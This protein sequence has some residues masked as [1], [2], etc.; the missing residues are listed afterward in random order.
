MGDGHGTRRK[1][2]R[3]YNVVKILAARSRGKIWFGVP[4][5]TDDAGVKVPWGVDRDDPS[6][7]QGELVPVREV[8]AERSGERI[9]EST[10]RN[11]IEGTAEQ[12]ERANDREALT[13][14][15]SGGVYP[16]IVWRRPSVL[17]GEISPHA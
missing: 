1:W 14:N 4:S 17:P 5:M 8:G 7:P 6:E 2:A 11:R 3:A 15:N 9:H 16:A 12:G 13:I 10:N